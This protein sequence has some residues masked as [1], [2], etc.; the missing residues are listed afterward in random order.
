MLVAPRFSPG[1]SQLI[2]FR[3]KPRSDFRNSS[4]PGSRP[5]RWAAWTSGP[6]DKPR[7]KCHIQWMQ[8]A[9]SK[10]KKKKPCDWEYNYSVPSHLVVSSY[11]LEQM[12]LATET[13]VISHQM[14]DS[15]GLNII[16]LTFNFICSAYWRFIIKY[17]EY[18][19]H[20][21]YYPF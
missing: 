20:L 19:I 6:Q 18:T 13:Y 14:R 8:E 1:I 15:V 17:C 12:H 3:T 10:A 9:Y 7:A 21:S 11:S 2:P 16:E 5:N 4:L